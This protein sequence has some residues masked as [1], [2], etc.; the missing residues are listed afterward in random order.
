VLPPACF[1]TGFGFISV[2]EEGK[3]RNSFKKN[4]KIDEVIEGERF[5]PFGF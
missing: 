4:P 3:S 1:E 5:M 2:F